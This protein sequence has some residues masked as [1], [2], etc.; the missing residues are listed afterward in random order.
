MPESRS[1]R[2]RRKDLRDQAHSL[3]DGEGTLRPFR[4]ND[5]RTLLPAVLQGKETVIGDAGSLRMAEDGEDA[6]LVG[7]FNFLSQELGRWKTAGKWRVH[8]IFQG[9]NSRS[10]AFGR[11]PLAPPLRMSA[12]SSSP[13]LCRQMNARHTKKRARGKA[14]ISVHGTGKAI[15]RM[16]VIQIPS[17]SRPTSRRQGVRSIKKRWHVQGRRLASRRGRTRSR[18]ACRGL[19]NPQN[20]AGG[21]HDFCCIKQYALIPPECRNYFAKLP[22]RDSAL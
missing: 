11:G 19:Q 18:A 5:A 17:L 21:A 4:G 15:R 20:C 13:T 9:L 14:F 12:A 3:V 1:K 22:G 8:A 7:G 6:A 10:A 16:L 2:V